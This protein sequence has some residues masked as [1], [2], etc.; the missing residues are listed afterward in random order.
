[1]LAVGSD[2][3][4][5]SSTNN[6]SSVANFKDKTSSLKQHQCPVPTVLDS[7]NHQNLQQEQTPSPSDH[8]IHSRLKS[9]L[10]S[11]RKEV[12]YSGV[13]DGGR[14]R[15]VASLNAQAMNQ[16]L[17]LTESALSVPVPKTDS[18]GADSTQASQNIDVECTPLNGSCALPNRTDTSCESSSSNGE[19]ISDT[20]MS[21]PL[22][23]PSSSSTTANTFLPTMPTG[24]PS[25][26]NASVDVVDVMKK[27]VRKQR[28][29]KTPSTVDHNTG[30]V[31]RIA[32]L[33]AQAFVS[34]LVR[35]SRTTQAG[36]EGGKKRLR[37]SNYNNSKKRKVDQNDVSAAEEVLKMG[38]DSSEDDAAPGS[39]EEHPVAQQHDQSPV[40]ASSSSRLCSSELL[41]SSSSQDEPSHDEALCS[42]ESVPCNTLGL[43]YSGDC[44]SANRSI[45]L[46]TEEH[47][48]ERVIPLIVPIHAFEVNFAK[49]KALKKT[50]SAV[51]K[52]KSKVRTWLIIII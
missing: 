51:G 8:Y 39:T 34:V 7:H 24:S 33:N 16:M 25:P 12:Y 35:S 45:L 3:G 48:P 9:A 2:S 46:T 31:K 32:S 14:V 36:G 19:A 28:N 43:L 1:M 10:G 21:S 42:L 27:R 52:R 40:C 18:P 37:N 41:A 26:K 23:S 4:M 17:C 5:N 44:I 11:G 29:T 22:S 6:N 50:S 47:L 15:R 38:A 20:V 49:A 13:L 30:F